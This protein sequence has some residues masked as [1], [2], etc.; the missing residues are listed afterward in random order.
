MTSPHSW[1]PPVSREV[2]VER[3]NLRAFYASPCRFFLDLPLDM[4]GIVVS[5]VDE[6]VAAGHV[7]SSGGLVLATDA[8][9]RGAVLLEIEDPGTFA[10]GVVRLDFEVLSRALPARGLDVRG[11]IAELA[12]W[13]RDLGH[14]VTAWFVEYARREDRPTALRAKHLHGALR[15]ERPLTEPPPPVR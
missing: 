5:T 15:G 9:F 1:A 7:L 4:T 8:Y 10:P 6:A 12:R 2:R 13:S 3:W 11:E 14:E